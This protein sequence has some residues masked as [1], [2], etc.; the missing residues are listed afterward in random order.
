MSHFYAVA[1]G[2]RGETTRTGTKSSGMETIAASWRGAISTYLYVDDQ[3]RDCYRVTQR[4]WHGQGISKT[5][6]EGVIGQE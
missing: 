6:A 5:L 4:P 3:G 2:A 1:K